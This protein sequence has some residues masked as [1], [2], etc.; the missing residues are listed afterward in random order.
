MS[1]FDWLSGQPGTYLPTINNPP[2]LILDLRV[3]HFFT[4]YH[5]VWNYYLLQPI[6]IN[7][8]TLQKSVYIGPSVLICDTYGLHKKGLIFIIAIDPLHMTS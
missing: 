4:K 3:G 6:A 5:D 1:M 7:M 2:W 8:N